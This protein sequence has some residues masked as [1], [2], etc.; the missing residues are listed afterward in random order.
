VVVDGD[1][2]TVRE[3][4]REEWTAPLEDVL[5]RIAG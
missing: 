3:R 4:G 1:R 5:E 2:A